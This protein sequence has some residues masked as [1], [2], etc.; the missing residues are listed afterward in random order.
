MNEIYIKCPNCNSG[1]NYYI[2]NTQ[3]ECLCEECGNSFIVEVGVEETPK[4]EIVK[5]PPKRIA[6]HKM[7]SVC[8]VCGGNHFKKSHLI[9][10]EQKTIG[11]FSGKNVSVGAIAGRYASAG[12]INFGSFEG[13]ILSQ[14]NLAAKIAPP[15]YPEFTERYPVK[16]AIPFI[17]IFFLFFCIVSHP[18]NLIDTCLSIFI[19]SVLATPFYLYFNSRYKD[20]VK[21]YEYSC[22]IHEIDLKRWHELID[23]WK[24]EWMCLSCGEICVVMENS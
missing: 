9:Y 10:Q 22:Y 18:T 6:T 2:G 5:E 8:K 24:K 21:I 3:N 16:S 11:H 1:S 14:S 12:T 15:P 20:A 17:I 23:F 13:K 7:P 4:P 19:S